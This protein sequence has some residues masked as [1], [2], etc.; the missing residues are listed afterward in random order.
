MRP[1]IVIA[2]LVV[3]G[4]AA[5]GGYYGFEVYPQRQFRA[6]LDQALATLPPGTTASYKTAHY[7]I[8]SNQTVVTGVTVHGE[9][10][11][12]PPLPFDITAATIETEK[13]NPDFAASWSRAL[14]AP[15]SFGADTPLPVAA[16]VIMT[17]ITLHSTMINLT[18]D[19]IHV[20]NLRLYPW[21]LLH[22]GMPS[23][24]DLQAALTPHPGP[25]DANDMQKILRAEAAIV[26]G[27]GYDGY[28]A[29]STKVTQTLPNADIQYDIR[30]VTGDSF[31]RGTIKGGSGEGITF[32]GS[33]FGT[34][35]IDRVAIGPTD[36]REPM[37]RLVNGEAL[38]AALLN[39]IQIGRIDY[40]G[41]T[42]QL[43]NGASTHIGG[44][45]LGPVAFASGMPVSGKLGWTDVSVARDQ[46]SDPRADEIF[47]K[48]GLQTM[49]LSFAFAYDWDTAQ[50]RVSLHDTMLQVNELGTLTIAADLTNAIPNP[51]GLSQ[52]RLAHARLRFDDA[53]LVNRVLRAGA[54]QSGSDP[55][56]D[57]AAYRQQIVNMVRQQGHTQG[58]VSPAWTAACNAAGDFIASPHSLT[59][60]LAPAQPVP[61]LALKGMPAPPAMLATT[62]G[63]VVSTSQ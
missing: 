2:T 35:S 10:P 42:A 33:R 58:V 7:S 23:W 29:G 6:G 40:S 45:S 52:I 20:T 34:V 1:S 36:I 53:S 41:I 14:A 30:K 25:P 17:G 55:G 9:I 48:L 63:L 5:G 8:L 4:L 28:D 22:A 38:S 43:P 21:A 59:I 61:L 62:L 47:D 44:L 57:P 54:G 15:A 11:G 24:Q 26:M 56:T 3:L 39:G 46:L 27:V 50:Q 13:P 60:E 49:T 16:S 18:E 12:N 51:V 19:S 37:T 32:R 31:D